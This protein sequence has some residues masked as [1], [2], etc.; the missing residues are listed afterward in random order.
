MRVSTGWGISTMTLLLAGLILVGGPHCWSAPIGLAET[1]NGH[2]AWHPLV[3]VLVFTF[4]VP[5]VRLMGTRSVPA[6]RGTASTF[7]FVLEGTRAI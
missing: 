5:I 3:L 2:A 1:G 6:C 4:L 7:E